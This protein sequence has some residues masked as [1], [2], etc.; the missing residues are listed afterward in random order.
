MGFGVHTPRAL[1]V[2]PTRISSKKNRKYLPGITDPCVI[3]IKAKNPIATKMK[4]ACF[5]CILW[6]S[7]KQVGLRHS[8]KK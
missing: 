4:A 2:L 6:S 8:R 7:K 3:E 5:C 1:P